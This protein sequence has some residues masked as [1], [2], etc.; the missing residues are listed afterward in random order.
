MVPVSL[1]SSQLD[2]ET[3]WVSSSIGRSGL[4]SNGGESGGGLDLPSDLSEDVSAGKV[5]D[6]VS[7][8]NGEGER[9]SEKWNSQVGE[10]ELMLT[11]KIPWAPDPL[12]WTT[13]SGIRSLSK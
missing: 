8:L 5:G 6:I 1:L 2:R 9:V 12:A 10:A 11:S 4:S 13:R 7:G 3:T